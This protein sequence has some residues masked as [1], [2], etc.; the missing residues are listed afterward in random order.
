MGKLLMR[1]TK[2]RI[3]GS[4]IANDDLYH[5]YEQTQVVKKHLNK[6]K[7]KKSKSSKL[8]RHTKTK[9]NKKRTNKK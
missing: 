4:R 1:H 6:I 2:K 8:R 5:H 7:N 9:K 3:G